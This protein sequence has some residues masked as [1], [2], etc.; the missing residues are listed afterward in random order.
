MREVDHH[1]EEIHLV[2]GQI[3]VTRDFLMTGEAHRAEEGVVVEDLA[4]Q[5]IME[6]VEAMVRV[7]VTIRQHQS[8]TVNGT[9]VLRI[10][11][12]V[13]VPIMERRTCL[14]MVVP[15]AI[16]IKDMAAMKV[17]LIRLAVLSADIFP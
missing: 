1:A 10:I 5:V 7:Q 9:A 4:Q 8:P 16:T 12:V 17:R 15:E 6:V 2:Q 3:V 11:M 13:K 14:T